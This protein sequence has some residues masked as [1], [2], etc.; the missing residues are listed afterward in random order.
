M[1][2]QKVA[3]ITPVTLY[4]RTCTDNEAAKVVSLVDVPHIANQS[5][6]NIAR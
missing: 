6:F 4:Y 2:Q 5:H 1:P 3:S